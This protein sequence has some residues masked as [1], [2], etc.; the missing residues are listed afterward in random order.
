MFWNVQGVYHHST[1]CK[2]RVV[3]SRLKSVAVQHYV[4][5]LKQALAEFVTYYNHF[6]LHSSL[7]HQPPVTRYLGVEAVEDH[8]LA[9]I[10]F[11]PQ[12][13][14]GAFPPSQ[15]VKV[16]PVNARTVQQRFALVPIGR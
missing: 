9:G 3:R 8:G 6:Q 16:L 1:E 15:P 7:G 4:A 10:P 11:F 13:L 5:K 12:E 14:V 2:S